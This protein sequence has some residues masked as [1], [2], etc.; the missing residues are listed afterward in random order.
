MY[1]R[2]TTSFA[3][4][5][6][7]LGRTSTAVFVPDEASQARPARARDRR[8]AA[9]PQAA[10]VPA[11]EEAAR[12]APGAPA[13]DRRGPD[14]RL[15]RSRGPACRGR[16]LRAG[17]LSR[18]RRPDDQAVRRP[19]RR[20]VRQAAERHGGPTR[21][22]PRELAA[23]AGGSRAGARRDARH[24]PARRGDR[25]I[26]FDAA[27]H[28]ADPGLD[29]IVEETDGPYAIRVAPRSR[30]AISTPS[31]AD[32]RRA[33]WHGREVR[34]RGRPRA[35][36]PSVIWYVPVRGVLRRQPADRGARRADAP[37]RPTR[38]SSR[39]GGVPSWVKLGLELFCA[40]GPALVADLRRAWPSGDARSQAA[41]HPG[42]RRR[43]RR[44]GS[45]GSAPGCSPSTP[46]AAARCSRP[47]SRRR[48]RPATREILAVTVLTSLDDTDLA[49]ASAAGA[50]SREL[51]RRRAR[52]RRARR[53]RRHRRVAPRGRALACARSRA[54]F[55]IVTPGV[56][57]AGSR[58]RRPEAR[59]DPARGA[60]GRRRSGRRRAAAT[61]RAG[62]G[63]RGPRDRRRAGVRRG[64]GQRPARGA[65][66]SG[67]V[68][69]YG[70]GPVREVRRAPPAAGAR[71][72][73]RS[74]ARRPPPAIRSRRSSPPAR[75]AGIRVEDRDRA[76]ARSRGRGGRPP[77]GRGRAGSA[78]SATP[79]VDELVAR[80]AE[81]ALL[82]AL[83][84]VEDPRNL[85]A[86]LRSAYLLGADG[87]IVPE[88]RAAQVTPAV[89]KAS[90]GASELVPIAQVGNLVRALERAARARRVAGRGA[91]APRTR[92]RSPRSTARCRCAS[93]SAPRAAGVRPLVAKHCDFHAVIPML[94]ARRR[95]VQRLGRRRARAL[96]DAAP[97]RALTTAP[98][99]RSTALIRGTNDF[100]W[101]ADCSSSSVARSR[102]PSIDEAQ[103]VRD[104]DRLGPRLR[105]RCRE[106]H[107]LHD[108]S[109]ARSRWR[110]FEARARPQ[111]DPQR[112][113]DAS[114]H[115]L[116]DRFERVHV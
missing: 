44:R 20:G 42:D 54:S 85:G 53:L 59:H 86:I 98:R 19:L 15:P 93:C 50:R 32:P 11:E 24:R 27:H 49:A 21:S 81:P 103:R 57:P 70:A 22:T 16:A 99:R 108:T 72:L 33:A 37:P 30:E 89:A 18:R 10:A 4:A 48:A 87:V 115:E 65:R 111:R 97:A 94:R 104:V 9:R 13:R 112:E 82:V 71:G 60:R 101:S 29:T 92:S 7:T 109:R 79:T 2:D 45:R 110:T 34:D 40:E 41:R 62:P 8:R 46:A 47:R 14:D 91:R 83:D 78:R 25:H 113:R 6:G 5:A 17:L 38:W 68:L 26:R 76:D 12:R 74:A 43:A 95:L 107:P 96:R 39:L 90:A 1:P 56:R 105:R 116:E 31:A 100:F 69:I 84:G 23:A 55:L 35:R 64:R 63:G 51:V 52:A 67:A 106:A 88:H 73:G 114:R 80:P 28:R 36:T 66:E 61:R 75:A 3:K 77:P 102:K 58:R